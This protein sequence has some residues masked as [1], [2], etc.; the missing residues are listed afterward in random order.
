MIR[1]VPY[2]RTYLLSRKPHIVKYFCKDTNI[3]KNKTRI[4]TKKTPPRY[5]ANE[6]VKNYF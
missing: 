6:V 4:N 5:Q 3:L 2:D 1:K